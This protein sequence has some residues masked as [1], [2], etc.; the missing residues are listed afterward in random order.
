MDTEGL[1]RGLAISFR[2][3]VTREW[4]LF[5]GMVLGLIAYVFW[6]AITASALSQLASFAD[7]PT[8][9]DPWTEQATGLTVVGLLLWILIPAIAAA[10]LVVREVTN[11]R[12]N[13]EKYYRIHPL[14]LLAP[15]LVLF[16]CCGIALVVV[17]P[18][19]SVALAAGIVAAVLLQIRTLT[20]SYRT[21]S[22]SLPRVQ[23]LGLFVTALV[24][25]LTLFLEGAIAIGNEQFITDV[26]SGFGDELG[27][28]SLSD[29]LETT[30]VG[31]FSVPTL[32]GI[33]I[34]VPVGLSLG[35]VFVQMIVGQVVRF[36][37]KKV[38]RSEL[39]TGQRYPEFARPT[40]NQT[41]SSTNPTAASSNRTS[42]TSTT[43]SGNSTQSSKTT[44]SSQSAGS[45][46]DTTSQ[47]GTEGGDDDETAEVTH[48]RVFT[49]DTE[50]DQTE[51]VGEDADETC[52]YCDAELDTGA[53]S[54]PNCGASL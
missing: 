30:E 46:D 40:T 26:V 21:F 24:V 41:S 31:D 5:A 12:N 14:L 45:V 54:C 42:T 29:L 11:I 13:L 27:L 2:S 20:Y 7:V 34:A 38:P 53:D 3:V 19:N 47:A 44:G 18:D 37:G 52:P 16:A 36:R 17:G 32:P 49:P 48:T 22:L 15:P 9:V 43:T 51:I 50:D 8:S 10:G 33:A 4:R 1:R 25:I 6:V 23:Q 39:R 35:Y 28:A